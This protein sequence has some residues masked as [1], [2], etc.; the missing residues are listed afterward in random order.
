M[1]PL[2]HPFRIDFGAWFFLLLLG[3]IT[4][5]LLSVPTVRA[6]LLSTLTIVLVTLVILWTFATHNDIKPLYIVAIFGFLL[7][8]FTINIPVQEI[9]LS[10]DAFRYENKAWLTAQS[11]WHPDHP[12]IEYLN[13]RVRSY[14]YVGAL[15]Y[16]LFGRSS[17]SLIVLNISFWVFAILCWM[18][19]AKQHLGLTRYGIVGFL[20]TLFPAGIRYSINIIREPLTHAFLALSFLFVFRWIESERLQYLVLSFGSSFGLLLLRPELFLPFWVIVSGVVFVAGPDN[21]RKHLSYIVMSAFSI[22]ALFAHKIRQ[23]LP[24]YADPDYAL[25]IT[26]LNVK[27]SPPPGATRTY[28]EGMEYNSWIDVIT[29][30]PV[31]LYNFIIMPLQFVPDQWSLAS[32]HGLDAVFVLFI[33]ILAILGICILFIRW[34]TIEFDANQFRVSTILLLYF[35]AVMSGYSLVISSP[36]AVRRRYVIIPV[37]VLFTAI[38]VAKI[39]DRTR[40]RF[41]IRAALND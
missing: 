12:P 35:F 11:W 18:I 20:L 23:M 13:L 33:I 41:E 14:A 2:A 37:I 21:C 27:L 15:I 28:L 31:R 4:G 32:K 7:L 24:R 36:A 5:L 25:D 40:W 30:L 39:V 16:F 38:A 1:I 26:V 10:P 6:V 8:I 22:G 19:I 29:F 3:V 34:F 9:T 17:V